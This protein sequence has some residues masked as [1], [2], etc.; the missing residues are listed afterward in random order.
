MP[1][2]SGSHKYLA[3]Q[4][5][6]Q[7]VVFRPNGDFL[8]AQARAAT[9]TSMHP[10]VFISTAMRC[11]SCGPSEQSLPLKINNDQLAK[12]KLR[13]TTGQAAQNSAAMKKPRCVATA[14]FQVSTFS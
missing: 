4:N 5:H 2:N 12:I 11:P 7:F 13:S 3:P 6:R 1:N 8:S 10:K 14:G 9:G